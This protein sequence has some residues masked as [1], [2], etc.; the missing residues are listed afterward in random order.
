MISDP[1][2]PLGQVVTTSNVFDMIPFEIVER[3]VLRHAKGDWG[4]LC[5]NDRLANE[6][7]LDSGGR[8]LSLYSTTDGTIWIIT[9]ADRSFTTVLLPEDY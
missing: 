4:E 6:E 8:I 7:A 9:E 2:F 3:C 5:E 1:K